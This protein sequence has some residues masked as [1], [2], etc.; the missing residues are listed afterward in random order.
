MK[1]P[2][3]KS[4]FYILL[5][6]I[7]NGITS[8]CTLYYSEI[9]FVLIKNNSNQVIK[10]IQL[11]YHGTGEDKKVWVGTLLPNRTYKYQINYF[12]QGEF[13][14]DMNY[15]I[16]NQ[17]KSEIVEGYAAPYKKKRYVIEIN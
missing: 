11:I 6:L 2:L 3:K 9:G 14:L 8:L 7:S 12:N 13:R 17:V 5:L 15:D 16:S 4:W 10:N 1:F